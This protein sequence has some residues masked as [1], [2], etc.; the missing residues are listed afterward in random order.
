M[1]DYSHQE[2]DFIREQE[3]DIIKGENFVFENNMLKVMLNAKQTENNKKWLTF[4]SNFFN[5]L[6]RWL[7][8]KLESLPSL[9]RVYR[10]YL[11]STKK[12][13]YLRVNSQR[14]SGLVNS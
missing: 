10:V 12:R 8:G 9:L 5:L 7:G 11:E 3:F 6:T 13:V 4:L 14:T 2:F 1:I